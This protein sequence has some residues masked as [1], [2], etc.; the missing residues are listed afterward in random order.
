MAEKLESYLNCYVCSETFRDPVSLGCH[1]SFCSSCLTKF[2]D[3]AENK[4][5]PV[6]E[7]KSSKETFDINLLLKDLADSFA[8]RH[9]AGPSEK[10]RRE[11]TVE[12]DEAVQVE[13]GVEVACSK[14]SEKFK[15]VVWVVEESEVICSLH[16]KKI[17]MFYQEDKEPVCSECHGSK[18]RSHTCVLVDKAAQENRV[19]G[20]RSSDK[21]GALR[22]KNTLEVVKVFFNG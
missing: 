15:T 6:C 10:R 4:N 18:H 13:E 12:V 1:H 7:R 8:G 3:Q 22:Y 11:E 19:R 5:C 17:W 20:R 21:H 14:Q 9:K 16:S 2:W